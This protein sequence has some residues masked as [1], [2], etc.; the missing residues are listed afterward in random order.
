MCY[1]Y[2]LL[3][4]QNVGFMALLFESVWRH[5]NSPIRQ[6][7]VSNFCPSKFP[8]PFFGKW[9]NVVIVCTLIYYFS[10]IFNSFHWSAV[11]T[12]QSIPTK[13]TRENSILWWNL[14][15][16]VSIFGT[17]PAIFYISLLEEIWHIKYYLVH[18]LPVFYISGRKSFPWRSCWK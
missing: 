7:Q 9:F 17:F 6:P 8:P 16:L 12:L 13:G 10:D 18:F 4:Y 5:L 2:I 11:E 3:F 14:A 1:M 15:I